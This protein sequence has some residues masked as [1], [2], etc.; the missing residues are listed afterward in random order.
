MK[1]EFIKEGTLDQGGLV[2]CGT[3]AGHVYG[4]GRSTY[5]GQ[6]KKLVFHPEQGSSICPGCTIL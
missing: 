5:T 3:P 2:P 4:N 6:S 1:D